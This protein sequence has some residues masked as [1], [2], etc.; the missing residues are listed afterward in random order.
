MQTDPFFIYFA[1]ARKRIGRPLR[2]F[3]ICQVSII[4][5]I[6]NSGD[7]VV[8]AEKLK[9]FGIIFFT[10]ICGS[11]AIASQE[12]RLLKFDFDPG[13]FHKIRDRPFY[14]II[15]FSRQQIVS[16][17]FIWHFF[18]VIGP[19]DFWKNQA[20]GRFL[21]LFFVFLRQAEFL[22]GIAKIMIFH[23]KH[24]DVILVIFLNFFIQ[25]CFLFSEN[26]CFFFGIFIFFH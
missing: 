10:V 7:E 12:H 13:I 4:F 21:T 8:D 26:Y 3:G 20:L 1:P 17:F 15:L 14:A 16:I 25:Y 23:I 18:V 24:F 22:Q 5:F 6:L 11:Q 9:W 19:Y 2:F